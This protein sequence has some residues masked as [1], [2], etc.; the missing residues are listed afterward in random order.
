M[1]TIKHKG[2]G[3]IGNQQTQIRCM[4]VNLQHSRTAT[5]NLMKL[6][7]QDLTDIVLVQEPY[8]IQNKLAGITRTHRTYIT[9]EERSRATIVIANEEIDAIIIKQLCDRDTIVA[10]VRYKSIRFLAASMY[11]DITEDINCSIAK[12]EEIL[13]LSTGTGIIIGIDSNSRSQAWHDK[14]TNARGRTLEEY[15]SSRDLNIMNEESE[16]TTYQ[17]TRGRS[18]IDVTITNN[19]LLK[20]LTDWQISTDDSLS[21]H[22]IIKFNIGQCNYGIQYKYTGTRYITTEETFRKFDDNLK[23]GIAKEFEMQNKDDFE[24]QDDILAK[25]IQDTDDIEQAV[26]K[27]QTAIT[28]SCKKSFKTRWNTNKMTKQKSVPWWTAELTIKRKRLNAL[29]R[30]YQRTKNNEE[31]R[32][33]RKKVYYEERKE[34]QTTIKK[35]K[36]KSWKEY[37]NL[38]SHTNPWN[39]IYKLAANKTRGSQMLTTLKKQD[40]TIT[41]NI[42]ETAKMMAEHLIPKDEDKDDT[43]YHKQIRKQVKESIQ[44]AE[45]R[46][47]TIEEVKN[48]IAELKHKKAPGEDT[49]TAEIYKRVYKQF[50]KSIYTLY[51][52]CLRRGQFPRKWKKVKIVPITKPGKENSS[53]VTKYRPISLVNVP[54]KVL[55][56]LLIN[57]IMHYAYQKEY[58]N[59]K[60]YG[61]T[62]QKSTI[63]ATIEVKDYLE[64]GLRQGQIAILLSLD[65][66][67]AFDSASWA[68]ILSAL[69]NFK[70]PKNLYMLARSYFSDRTAVLSTNSIHIEQEVSNGCPQGS[71]CGPAFWNIQFNA[72]LNINYEKQTKLTAFADD[73]IIAVRAE[74][75]REAE[76]IINIELGKITT[77]AKNNKISFNETKSKVMLITRRKRKENKEL[78]IYLNNVKLEQVD[79]IKY[80]GIIMDNKINFREHLLYT[81][82]KCTKLIHTLSKS[83]KLKWGLSS[84]ALRTIYKGA[85]MPLMLYGAPVWIKAM[86]KKCNKRIYDRVQRLINIKIAKAFRTTS[87]EALCIVTGLIPITIQAEEEANIYNKIRK[88][89]DNEIDKPTPPKDW[90]HPA[91]SVKITEAAEDQV[92]Q[93]F[94]DGSKNENGVGAGIAIF[95]DGEIEQQLKYK[96]NNDCSNNQAEQLAITKALEAIDNMYNRSS[97]RKTVTIYTDSRIT[98]LSLENQRNHSNLIDTIRRKTIALEEQGWTIKF[99]WIKAHDGNL[100][101]ELADKLAKQATK[102]KNIIYNKIPKSQIIQ[103]EKQQSID[104]WQKQ[105]DQTTKG[106]M[107]KQFFPN[108]KDRLKQRI[109]ISPNLTAILT[110]HGKTKAYLNRFNIIESPQCTCKEGPQTVDHLIYECNMLQ[111]ERTTLV[112]NISP[113]AWP[114]EKREL[115]KNH[116]KHFTQFINSIDFEVINSDIN[117]E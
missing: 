29:R 79:K 111:T 44:T 81:A 77:W 45:D 48:A 9:N 34:Y 12:I 96:L 100:G 14:Q 103:R 23:E 25:Y 97:I 19:S 68:S 109:K 104:K 30:L 66:K 33:H 52:E 113:E 7:Q 17:S 55:E 32:N 105:W 1:A 102:N 67:A 71:S 116:T 88:S 40:G 99:T 22:N 98:I 85:I 93:I 57:R 4:Q 95:I 65:V 76:N 115:I 70:C 63:D 82:N 18:N 16:L 74:S 46:E 106:S 42:E 8:I 6:I 37:C 112:T 87:N 92:I 27:L 5:D 78:A 84:E 11:F 31:L 59:R 54:G 75:I 94:T 72:L 35:E 26:G 56:K 61:F 114:K 28:T 64:E 47:Y 20:I 2:I 15:L 49:I 117:S 60:Q 36:I 10:E 3:I 51:N 53:D 89:T 69:Q 24:T 43:D 39:A 58:M 73:L 62:P 90:I 86:E 21:D 41:T 107:T 83:A 38:T 101:N 110:A 80:L 50:P 13:K 91:D 108:I